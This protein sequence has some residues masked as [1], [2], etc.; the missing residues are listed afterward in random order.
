MMR[1]EFVE[2]HEAIGVLQDVAQV[3]GVMQGL[4]R[5]P[6]FPSQELEADEG[7]Q[8][9]DADGEILCESFSPEKS[10]QL[11]ICTATSTSSV[12]RL[13]AESCASEKIRSRAPRD[14]RQRCGNVHP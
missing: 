11:A 3:S 4:V 14:V 13:P 6:I 9:G 12:T 5:M 2:A 1:I 10:L 7:L 8:R